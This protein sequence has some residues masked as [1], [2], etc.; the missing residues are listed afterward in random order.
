MAIKKITE[1]P[2][3]ATI[4]NSDILPFV[5]EDTNTTK[6]V[7]VGTLISHSISEMATSDDVNDL[8]DARLRFHGLIT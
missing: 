7:A 6:S 8:I 5:D 4:T 3:D 1:L 2:V